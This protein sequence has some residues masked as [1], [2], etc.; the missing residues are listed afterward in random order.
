[1]ID[2]PA[3][4]DP[5]GGTRRVNSLRLGTCCR[6]GLSGDEST[7]E[8]EM[9]LD[10]L[11]E[12]DRLLL[13]VVPLDRMD[14]RS[15]SS[16][17]VS[18]SESVVSLPLL[19]PNASPNRPITAIVALRPLS[20]LPLPQDH[21]ELELVVE[22]PPIVTASSSNRDMVGIVGSCVAPRKR[23]PSVVKYPPREGPTCV[24]IPCGTTTCG[25]C[26]R[27]LRS[28]AGV[29]SSANWGCA[30]RL[31]PVGDFARMGES[32][33]AGMWELPGVDNPEG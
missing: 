31:A 26:R 21:D 19:T 3:C 24:G 2:G 33:V 9:V 15:C 16:S 27:F 11:F 1:M 30:G 28:R 18:V 13:R 14:L 4:G 32:V 20:R 12:N 25:A 10:S 22:L 8:R 7:V 5:V 6:L 23:S 17:E 29:R